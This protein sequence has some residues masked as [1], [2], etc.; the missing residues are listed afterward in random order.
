MSKVLS[1]DD[2]IGA[3]SIA[4]HPAMPDMM[5]KAE[6]LADEMGA[7]LAAHFN[8]KAGPASCELGF[9]GT[10]VDFH[11][12][13]D[14]QECPEAIDMHD[15]GGEWGDESDD[16]DSDSEDDGPDPLAGLTVIAQI[17]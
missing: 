7:L 9:G 6:A 13:F 14:G 2:M 3:L 10:C 5:M 11:P 12:A 8:I 15:D 16:D 17:D 4:E 1:I